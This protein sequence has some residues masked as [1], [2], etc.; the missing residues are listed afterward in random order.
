[1]TE[2]T[3]FVIFPAARADTL[4]AM[5]HQTCCAVTDDPWTC[6]ELATYRAD[7]APMPGHQRGPST[8]ACAHHG[9]HLRERA[10]LTRIHSY[11]PTLTPCRGKPT[12]PH[13]APTANNTA[14]NAN[15]T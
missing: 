1:M 5:W 11:N 2:P 14:P 13:D 6:P 12:A 10:D 3:A 9:T 8:F 4:A 7:L 15:A